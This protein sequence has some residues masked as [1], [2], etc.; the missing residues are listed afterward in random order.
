MNLN[1]SSEGGIFTKNKKNKKN[2]EIKIKCSYCISAVTMEHN[3]KQKA[4]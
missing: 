4:N 2:W 3:L 1:K